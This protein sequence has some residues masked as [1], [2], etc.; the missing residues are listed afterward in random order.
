V[1]TDVSSAEILHR[2]HDWAADGHV[3]G[4]SGMQCT[5]MLDDTGWKLL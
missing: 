4:E 3:R 1:R 5:A 2:L